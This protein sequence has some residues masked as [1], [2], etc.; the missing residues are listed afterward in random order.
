MLHDAGKI[1]LDRRGRRDYGEFLRDAA[2]F[3]A[4][5]VEQER[6]TLGL[7]HDDVGA[8][9]CVRWGLP[10]S[11]AIAVKYHHRRLESHD[12]SEEESLLAWIVSLSN[13]LCRMQDL[14]TLDT[15]TARP[16]TLTP[17]VWEHIDLERMDLTA[18][19][20]AM[21]R[22]MERIS[23]FH[24]VAFPAPGRIQEDLI[25]SIL[26]LSKANTGFL[27]KGP[28][29][30][31]HYFRRIGDTIFPGPG[32]EL[33]TALA[34]AK[35][36]K[37]ILDVLMFRIGSIFE[38]VHWSLLLKDPKTKDMV[39][40]VVEGVNKEKLQG[41]RLAKGE[42][43]AGSLLE[44]GA[45]LLV[46][47]V[48]RQPKHGAGGFAGLEARSCMG[49]LLKSESTIFG[50]IELVNKIKGGGFTQEEFGLLQSIAE[51]AAMDMERVYYQQALKKMAATDSLTGLKNRYSLERVLSNREKVLKDFGPGV[52]MMIIDIDKFKQINETRGRRKADELLQSIAGILRA[53]FRKTD[54]LFRY[55]RTSLWSFCRGPMGRRPRPGFS[56]PLRPA[57]ATWTRPSASSCTR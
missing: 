50:V 4:S 43:F 8:F 41:S 9:L 35:T 36:I 7:G 52:S 1:L 29:P 12:F 2:P 47:D 24:Q 15:D 10:D 20:N 25:R 49:A 5:I 21:H 30:G 17:E 23:E 53:T 27:Y 46:E 39:Y 3:P 57:K 34:K 56:T 40:A 19:I 32:F 51:H 33:G 38:P 48:S 42:G 44:T 22:E 54:D 16:L 18:C 13:S 14:G 31:M 26:Q 45:G 55:E 11:V 6:K 37:E 28:A